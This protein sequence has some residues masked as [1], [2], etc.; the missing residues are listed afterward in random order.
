M[1]ESTVERELVELETAYWQALKDGDTAALSR[2]TDFPCLVLGAQGV[3]SVDEAHLSAIIESASW[4]ID[5]FAIADDFEVRLLTDDIALVAYKVHE[6]LTVEGEPVAVD[7]ADASVWV[8]RQGHWRCAMHT[9]SHLG[10]PF[11]RDRRR[12]G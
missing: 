7:A 11:G 8:R 9:E 10:D 6:E 3:M 2:L 12:P 5:A 1:V 4:S